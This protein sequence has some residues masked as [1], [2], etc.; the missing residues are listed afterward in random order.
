[1]VSSKHPFP[2]PGE[3]VVCNVVSIQQGYVQVKL[4]D[5]KGTSN[6]GNL[7]G[8]VHISELSNR[9]VKNIHS[10]ISVGQKVVLLVLRV[11]EERGYV[12][13]SL[14]R[15]TMEQKTNKMN[16]WR[17]AVKAEN[18]LKFFAEQHKTT[19]EDIV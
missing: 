14:R 4:E 10:L 3:L 15:V 6:E 19:L 1:M 2:I 18:L 7:I 11:N 9:W 5:Y 13:L 12:D 16:D 8:M 17:Y